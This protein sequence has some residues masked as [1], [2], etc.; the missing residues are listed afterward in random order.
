M[1]NIKHLEEAGQN[2]FQHMWFAGWVAV[3][4][5]VT[6]IVLLLHAILP[7]LQMPRSLDIARTS[8]FLFDKD[9]DLRVRKMKVMD[10]D[11]S[12]TK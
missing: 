3:R 8:D 10:R 4:L 1:I 6:A 12:N 5:L 11:A 2:Y 7:I 9:Y